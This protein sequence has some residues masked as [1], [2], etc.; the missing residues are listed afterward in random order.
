MILS[1]DPKF[2]SGIEFVA[3]HASWIPD[4]MI[5]Y[6]FIRL[7]QMMDY[8]SLQSEIVTTV[9]SR[10]GVLESHDI[11]AREAELKSAV[12]QLLV[13]VLKCKNE[14]SLQQSR[15]EDSQKLMLD[16]LSDENTAVVI[17]NLKKCL[18]KKTVD[19]ELSQ[20]ELDQV[21]QSKAQLESSVSSKSKHIEKLSSLLLMKEEKILDLE[22]E[23]KECKS[24]L[25]SSESL[26]DARSDSSERWRQALQQA[27]L[28]LKE[29]E[30]AL[31]ATEEMNQDL[32]KM[33]DKRMSKPLVSQ[34][35]SYQHIRSFVAIPSNPF[36]S[37]S[38]N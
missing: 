2:W 16:Q 28:K 5:I 17:R 13:S 4:A 21:K 24:K 35:I 18:D 29:R 33:L 6:Y 25:A 23:L 27:N 14:L 26:L 12:S 9:A 20:Q 22:T 8:R 31:K 15:L 34:F 36:H 3:E 10:V 19:A 11:D 1:A 32:R 38:I 30:V 37:Q 7:L